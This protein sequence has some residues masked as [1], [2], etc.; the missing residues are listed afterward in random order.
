MI[1][2]KS[3]KFNKLIAVVTAIA[4]AL[5]IIPMVT[6]APTPISIVV[7][8]SEGEI[9]VDLRDRG[10]TDEELA[11]MVE[12]SLKEGDIPRSTINHMEAEMRAVLQ[13]LEESFLAIQVNETSQELDQSQIAKLLEDVLAL[14]S[15]NKMIPSDMLISLESVPSATELINQI[16]D[17]DYD[18]AIKALVEI[19]RHI[20]A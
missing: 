9:R 6:P 3:R 14:L 2:I 15:E 13:K 17:F 19:K 12:D 11:Q 18:A 1:S 5:A 20:I 7:A 10:I 8:A 16:E 4:I